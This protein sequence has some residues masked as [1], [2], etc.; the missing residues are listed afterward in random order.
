MKIYTKD[1]DNLKTSTFGRRVFKDDL[2]IEASGTIDELQSVIMVAY[3]HIEDES[4][5]EILINAC[6]HLFTI[7]FDITSSGE[8]FS[9]DKVLEIEQTIDR[10]ED[11]LPKVTTFIVPGLTKESSFIHLARTLARRCERVIVKYALDNFVNYNILKY[12]NR[13]SDLLFVLGRYVELNK[14]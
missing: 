11:L 5:K 6:K 13:L 14:K 4:V 1:G 8:N 2:V 10:Y 9:Q 7:G 12:I 3:N